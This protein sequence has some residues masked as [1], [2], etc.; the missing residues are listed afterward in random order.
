MKKLLAVILAAV[1]L[2]ALAACGGSFAITYD[3]GSYGSGEVAAGTKTKGEDFTLSSQT[4]TR[5]GYIQTGW[6]T[7]DGGAKVYHLGGQYKIDAKITLYPFWETYLEANEFTITYDPGSHGGAAVAAGTKIRGE[8]FTLSSQTFTR[9]GYTQTGWSTS[10]GGAKAYGLGGQYTADADITLYPFWTQYVSLGD[11]IKFGGI[12]WRVLEVQAGKAL[13][14]SEK[15]LENRK[16]DAELHNI[17]WQHC[18][19]REYLNGEFYNST[20]SAAEKARI[21]TTQVKNDAN[22]WYGISGGNG[23]S[24]KLFL[25]SLEEVVRYFGDSGKLAAEDGS[26]TSTINDQY[27]SA[28]IAKDGDGNARTWWLRSPGSVTFNAASVV[29]NGWISVS[30]DSLYDANVGVRP[31]LWL[32][33]E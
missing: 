29:F 24:D 31:A 13:L 21:A 12:D 3:P 1:L 2:L 22:P 5:D 20:F 17:T 10:D 23:T 8:D 28:R 7:S 9:D 33:L 27:N 11:I 6:S 25:L 18:D 26:M 4:F 16:Y 30:G 15:V 32:N 19:L 14:I